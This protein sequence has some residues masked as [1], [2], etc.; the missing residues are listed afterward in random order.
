[1]DCQSL[2]SNRFFGSVGR[3]MFTLYK[4]VTGGLSWHDATTPLEEVSWVAVW[5]F[6]CY[7]GFTVLAVLNVVTGVFCHSAIEASTADKETA[8]LAQ[9]TNQ[10]HYVEA[11]KKVFSEIDEDQ[12]KQIT[13]D[14][15]EK[16]LD[17]ENMA[18][19]FHSIDIDTQDAWAL[20]KL[21]DNDGSGCIDLE[22]F[23]SGCLQLRGSAKAI[24]VAKMSYENKSLRQMVRALAGAMDE[25]IMKVDDIGGFLRITV[26]VDE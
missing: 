3:S 2:E 12:S 24:H 22:E 9:L 17:D 21:I 19:Y 10:K 14:E 5:V 4:S 20:F 13:I 8:V 6:V 26:E 7:I 18:A 15:F 1:M 25:M 23:V 11:I 16:K